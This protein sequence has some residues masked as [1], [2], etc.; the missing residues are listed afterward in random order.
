MPTP[1]LVE[2]QRFTF[3]ETW[4]AFKYDES[5]FYRDRVEP[6]LRGMKAVD[7]VADRATT[8]FLLLLEAK[9]FR[10]HRIENKDRLPSQLAEEVAVKVQNTLIALLGA[11]RSGVAEFDATRLSGLLQATNE[12]YVVL[13][14]EDDSAVDLAKWKTKLKLLSSAVKKHLSWL[15]PLKVHAVSM[16]S[17]NPI[18]DLKVE[19]LS[20]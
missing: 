7:I 10:G 12:I 9:D 3:G 1:L 11:G 13:W 2:K 17:E 6:S 4:N 15:G 20:R 19:N 16:K 8:N 5:K 18:P 14:I